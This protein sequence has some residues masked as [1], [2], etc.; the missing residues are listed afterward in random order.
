MVSAFARPVLVKASGSATL[1]E[2]VALAGGQ[3]GSFDEKWLQALLYAHPDT[4]PVAEIDP[5]IGPLIPI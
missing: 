1:L 2:R 3:G 5:H 4:L